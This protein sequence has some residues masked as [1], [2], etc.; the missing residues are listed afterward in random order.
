MFIN[1]VI[2]FGIEYQHHH[3]IF[4][5][6]D[7]CF[8]CRNELISFPCTKMALSLCSMTFAKNTSNKQ[9]N[10]LELIKQ[11]SLLIIHVIP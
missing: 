1:T 5:S 2:E 10:Y 7:T 6:E 9:T 3:A 11:L 4:S 8:I